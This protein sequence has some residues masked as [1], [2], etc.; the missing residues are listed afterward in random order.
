MSVMVFRA[1]YFAPSPA[2]GRPSTYHATI[3]SEEWTSALAEALRLSHTHG[4]LYQL[5]RT[6]LMRDDVASNPDV[7]TTA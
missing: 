6:D 5:Q 7:S 1:T 3:A 2:G 4:R